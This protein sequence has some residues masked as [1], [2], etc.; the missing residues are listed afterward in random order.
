MPALILHSLLFACLLLGAACNK[1]Q[2]VNTI[3]ASI[4]ALDA[5]RD[6]FV[7]WDHDHQM[8]I[9]DAATSR[10]EGAAKLAAYRKKRQDVLDGFQIAYRALALAATQ[11]DDPSLKAALDEAGKLL[12]LITQLRGG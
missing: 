1:D 8:S 12:L 11:T 4:V 5:A 7:Q 6:G 9:V 3:H 10:E 2:R